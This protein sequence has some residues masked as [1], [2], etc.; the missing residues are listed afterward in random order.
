MRPIPHAAGVYLGVLQLVFALGWTTYAVY[1][2]KLAASVGLTSGAVILILMLDQVIFTVTDFAMGIAA[3]NVSRLIGRLGHW[4]AAITLVSCAAF[5]GLPFI[6]G[7][8]LGSTV[9]L[10]L[11]VIWAI[12]SSALRAPPL[13]LLGKYAAKRRVE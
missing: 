1:L 7:A 2:P 10:V 12:T 3:D 4:V 5:V 6:A 9:F 13:M 11:T 8:R